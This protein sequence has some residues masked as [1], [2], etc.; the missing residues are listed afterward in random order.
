MK[1]GISAKRWH[2]KLT[3]DAVLFL[4][5]ILGIIH[6]T[7]VAK[8][9]RPELLVVFAGM[10]GLPAFLRTDEAKSKIEIKD[11]TEETPAAAELTPSV[12]PYP[13]YPPFLP[14]GQYP[15]PYPVYPPQSPQSDSPTPETPAEVPHKR[16][17]KPIAEA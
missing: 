7:V 12:G 14:T 9:Q 4:V 11:E 16:R 1:L 17:R 13:P 10:V 8:T 5:G 6:E 15:Y 3:R 2:V